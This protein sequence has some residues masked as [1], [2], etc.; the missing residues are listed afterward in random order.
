MLVK[1]TNIQTEARASIDFRLVLTGP[2][3]PVKRWSSSISITR[4]HGVREAPDADC[5]REPELVRGIGGRLSSGADPADLPLSR[6]IMNIMTTAG[7]EPVLLPPSA[8][9]FR[10]FCFGSLTI[11]L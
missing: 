6:E 7:H 1:S 5:V 9:V 10:C 2:R 11:H 4:L 8:V 3:T